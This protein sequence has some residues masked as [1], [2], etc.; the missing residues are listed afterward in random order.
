MLKVELIHKVIIRVG[1]DE[2][3]CLP[4]EPHVLIEDLEQRIPGQFKPDR[5]HGVVD[6]PQNVHVP[7]TGRNGNT[8]HLL[9]LVQ[10]FRA[11]KRGIGVYFQIL[12][13]QA[14]LKIF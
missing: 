3:E 4:F 1:H 6:M 12:E 8:K 7:E 2:G 11:V 5:G 14:K 13:K 9:N 10:L